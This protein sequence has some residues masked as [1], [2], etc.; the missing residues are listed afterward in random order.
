M[1]PS[2]SL[3]LHI[4]LVNRQPVIEEVEWKEASVD[5]MIWVRQIVTKNCWNVKVMAV[6]ETKKSFFTVAFMK[7]WSGELF[8]MMDSLVCLLAY[9]I[10]CF[11]LLCWEGC[12]DLDWIESLLPCNYVASMCGRAEGKCNLFSTYALTTFVHGSSGGVW[13]I[14][15]YCLWFRLMPFLIGKI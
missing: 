5:I 4:I 12:F 7:N 9:R 10:M 14:W 8:L 1:P 11:Y 2:L 3:F 15:N 6:M 13:G